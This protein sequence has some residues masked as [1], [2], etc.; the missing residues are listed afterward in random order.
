MKK[1]LFIFILVLIFSSLLLAEVTEIDVSASSA[2]GVPVP[3]RIYMHEFLDRVGDDFDAN[4]YS[5]RVVNGNGEEIEFQIDDLDSNGKISSEDLL[6]FLFQEKAKILVSTDPSMDLPEFTPALE[7]EKNESEFIISGAGISKSIKI[8]SHGFANY[9]GY[10]ESDSLLYG[11]LGIFRVAGWKGSTYWV[12]GNYGSKHEEKTSYNFDTVE[13]KMAG[14]GPIG[15]TFQAKL[16]S[17]TFPGLTQ[18]VVTTVLKTGE[19]LV[20]SRIIFENY[21]D[22]MKLQLMSTKPLTDADQESVLHVLPLFR[23][24]VWS[25]QINSTPFE[26]WKSRNAL[27]MVNSNPYIVFS[28][29][30]SVNPLWW[31]ASYIFAS[32]EPWRA[33]YS[34][35]MDLGVYEILPE[36]PLVYSDFNK[37]VLGDTWVYESREFRDGIF[38]WIPGEFEAYEPTKGI[39]SMDSNNWP[40]HFMAGDEVVFVRLYGIA[41]AGDVS[42]LIEYL[43]ARS[44]EFQ[45][46]KILE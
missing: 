16:E 31:G 32:Q 38:R 19:V 5:M 35:D 3:Y 13:L 37:F 21:A 22:M 46:V 1:N 29:V 30:D 27:K 12:N 4:W 20:D 18:K 24:M 15:A 9:V 10:G 23:K 14:N 43:E 36:K 39:V 7:V 6:T 17:G 2:T 44:V 11:E 40:M 26:Y 28:A 41:D 45:S 33:N 34:Q 42:D 8:D 25:E